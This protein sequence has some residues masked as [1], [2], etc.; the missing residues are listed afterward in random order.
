MQICL[1][2]QST[3]HLGLKYSKHLAVIWF[4]RFLLKDGAI[5]YLY[6]PC[7]AFHTDSCWNTHVS[8][9]VAFL[10]MAIFQSC[11]NVCL[12]ACVCEHVCFIHIKNIVDVDL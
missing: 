10:T 3:I 12:H 11:V 1:E 6:N 7:Q 2:M 9:A 8:L 4:R 5:K